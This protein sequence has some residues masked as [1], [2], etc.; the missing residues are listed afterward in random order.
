MLEGRHGQRR[1]G[2]RSEFFSEILAAAIA[3]GPY[4]LHSQTESKVAGSELSWVSAT[5][6][7]DTASAIYFRFKARRLGRFLT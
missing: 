1:L 7:P 6:G 5:P 2:S 4:A 3:G